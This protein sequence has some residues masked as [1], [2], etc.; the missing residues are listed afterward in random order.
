MTTVSVGSSRKAAAPRTNSVQIA[1]RCMAIN[2]SKS[3]LY[4]VVKEAQIKEFLFSLGEAHNG[5]SIANIKPN[6][7]FFE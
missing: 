6:K 2:S 3:G 5:H 1:P 7:V 4:L